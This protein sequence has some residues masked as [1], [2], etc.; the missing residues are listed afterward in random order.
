MKTKSCVRMLLAIFKI[1]VA[2][3][4]RYNLSKM[5]L[6]GYIMMCTYTTINFDQFIAVHS[7]FIVLVILCKRYFSFWIHRIQSPFY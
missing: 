4:E 2:S 3:K 7:R 6:V 1:I 5:R